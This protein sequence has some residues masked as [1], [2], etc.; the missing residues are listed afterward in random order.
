MAEE[1]QVVGVHT[2]DAWNQQLQNGKDSQ[3]LVSIQT[4]LN[5]F[6]NL[7]S[8][9]PYFLLNFV[10]NSRSFILLSLYVLNPCGLQNYPIVVDF[11]ASWC[12]PC[13]FIAPVLAEI[14]RHTPQVIFLKV[15]VDEVRPVA[16]EYSIEAMPTF[17][18]LKDGKIVDKVVGAKKEELQLTIA[19]H[20]S[21]AAAS[22]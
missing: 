18:F 10:L 20:V 22:S 1:G 15:D 2:V 5:F 11:T 4:N 12:G 14:A 21:A 8:A 7:L 3:K 9:P 13:R 6:T 17:L 19:K 16:E